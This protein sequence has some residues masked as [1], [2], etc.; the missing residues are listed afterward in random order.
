[1]ASKQAV[2]DLGG[3]ISVD[4]FAGGGGLS[5]AYEAATGMPV[6]IAVNHSDNALSMHRENHPQTR[7][8]IADVFEVDPR[9]A[10]QGRPVGFLHLSPDCTHFSQAKGGQARS[11]KIRG[12]SWVAARWAGQV[13]PRVIT[14]ENVKQI[15]G[16]C[17]LIAKRDPATG[18]VVTLDEIAC[19]KTGKKTFRVADRGEYVPR[20]NQ[21][22]VPDKRRLGQT[23]KRFVQQLEGM[24]YVVEWRILVAADY[25]APTTRERLFMVARCDGAP[26]T[27]PEP[28]H[29]KKPK[30]GQKKW[31]AAAEC[32]DWS[33]PCPSIF[34][35][36]RPLADATLR[37]IARGLK[38]YVIDAAEPFIVNNMA[39]NVPRPASEP[40]AT[41]ATGPHKLLVAPQIIPA[42]HQGGDR[43]RGIDE[44]LPTI[45]AAHRGEQMLISPT[46]APTLLKIRGDSD[47]GRLDTPLPTIT[48]GAGA[49]RD[50]GAAHA[51]GVIT[52]HL[53]Q[54]TQ[55]GRE[56]GA[57]EPLKTI[58]TAKGGEQAVIAASLIQAAH[59]EGSG[60]TKRRG[61]GAHDPEAPIGTIHAGG[62]SFGAV[63]AML[64]QT[65]YGECAGQAP[66]SLDIEQPLGTVV[67]GAAKHAAVAAFLAQQNTMPNGGVHAGH[68]AREPV[69]TITNSGSHQ[70]V[71]AASLAT[72]RGTN[73]GRGAD[74]P[75]RTASGGGEHHALIEYTLSPD[76]EA[77]ALRVAALLIRY[78][79]EGGQWGDLRDPADTITA[80]DRI[81]LVTVWLRGHPYVIVD[82]GLRMLTPRELYRAQGFPDG[83]IIERGHDGRMFSK[84]DQVRMVGNSVSPPPAEALI[85]AN[86][87]H[88][89]VL[90]D[91]LRAA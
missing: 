64:V 54:F 49:K 12:L 71:V 24:G 42:T 27:W 75:L 55:G 7:H 30:R 5:T 29:F 11:S 79:S 18:R 31:R 17:Q 81:A 52:A 32:I 2:L 46:I 35:R 41:A 63:A 16:W 85:K 28:T 91:E 78:Y 20:H 40:M 87:Q 3:E 69:S 65:G 19:P 25:G 4:L 53:Q 45:T 14:L 61:S 13:R 23:W 39:N 8:F 33:I 38:R 59:G 90:A 26:I 80:K 76:Q 68:D 58:T 9:G 15:F 56:H 48:S 77:G 72:L 1:M 44:P 22:L 36:K 47:G 21:F 82:V 73:V 6:T 34:E 66:R 67:G 74:E 62:G 50:A 43:G 88:R 83:Y 51:M 89:P 84:S 10:A 57:A 70:N 37:R 60:K 86:Y